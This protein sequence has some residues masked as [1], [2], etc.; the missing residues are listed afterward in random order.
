[1]PWPRPPLTV[2]QVLAWADA[3]RSRTGRWPHAG[4]GPVAGAPGETWQAVSRALVRDSRGLP[5]GSSLASLLEEHRGKRNKARTP[6]LTAG[7]ILQWAHA[8]R[9][10]TGRWPR[11]DSGPVLDA[12][13]ESWRAVASA[14]FAGH[15]GL[16][17]GD[18]LA[19]LL[20]HRCG[21][22]D[23]PR[24]ARLTGAAAS[25]AAPAS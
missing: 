10:R 19:R 25:T 14:L 7:Q 17:G 3:H 9:R 5:G 23:R 16:R 11:P 8:H 21:H 2:A 22:P 4:S 24:P 18:T 1:L 6:P 12:P 20:S 15:R 13:G